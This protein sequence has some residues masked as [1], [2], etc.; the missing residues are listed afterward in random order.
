[1]DPHRFLATYSHHRPCTALGWEEGCGGTA[2][3]SPTGILWE[4]HGSALSCLQPACN[5]LPSACSL[6][7]A[8]RGYSQVHPWRRRD[9]APPPVHPGNASR[10]KGQHE[11]LLL[12]PTRTLFAQLQL[13]RAIAA[14]PVPIFAA[15]RS[16]PLHALSVSQ[17]RQIHFWPLLTGNN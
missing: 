14:P 9:S 15:P 12:H 16:L 5:P 3:P 7:A 17:P 1:M 11:L 13:H 6:L 8:P 2:H 10:I 4:R